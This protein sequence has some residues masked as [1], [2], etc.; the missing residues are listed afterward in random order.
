MFF[1]GR[2]HPSAEWLSV[3]HRLFPIGL[4]ILR[5][6]FQDAGSIK[7]IEVSQGAIG[8][9]EG[10]LGQFEYVLQTSLA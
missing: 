5:Y 4:R 3:A 9:S 10:L 1:I 6:L 2:Y 7:V 8:A